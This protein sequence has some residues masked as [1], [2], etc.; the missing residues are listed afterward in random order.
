MYWK[1]SLV[2]K[3]VCTSR[4]DSLLNLTPLYTFVSNNGVSVSE[5]SAVN[6]IIVLESFTNPT[7]VSVIFVSNT[8]YGMNTCEDEVT[9][10]WT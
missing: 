2:L 8:K 6:L 4:I 7:R 9:I 3:C 10:F 5:I 1:V